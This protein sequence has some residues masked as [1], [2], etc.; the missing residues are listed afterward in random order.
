MDGLTISEHK[1]QAEV[2]LAKKQEVH[3]ETISGRFYNGIIKSIS[4]E[5][6]T[7]AYFELEDRK[8]GVIVIWFRNLSEPLQPTVTP[9]GKK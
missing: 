7:K 3:V 5:S 1:E 9:R 2:Y 4:S 6:G 8:L